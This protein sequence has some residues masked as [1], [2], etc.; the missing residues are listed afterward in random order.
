M[1]L[2]VVILLVL[3]SFL[4][5]SDVPPNLVVCTGNKTYFN[6]GGCEA[7]CSDHEQMMC[8]TICRESGCYCFGDEYAL[9]AKGNCILKKDCDLV[10]A[11][12]P[13]PQNEVWL[14]CGPSCKNICGTDHVGCREY[15][16]PRACYCTGDYALEKEGGKCILR[17]S[18]VPI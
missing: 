4:G 1:K 12:F 9:D 18:C 5:A 14:E 6:C 15:C 8:G 3:I 2:E 13:C 16:R 10:G 17:S 7:K 11:T